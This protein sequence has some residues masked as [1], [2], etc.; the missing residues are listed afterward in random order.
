MDSAKLTIERPPASLMPI[1]EQIQEVGLDL[2][3]AIRA[4]C[5]LGMAAACLQ[6]TSCVLL[7]SDRRD[8]NVAMVDVVVAAVGSGGE[9]VGAGGR[10]VEL[11]DG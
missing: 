6:P 10:V 3:Y 11:V 1:V 2:E 8:D 5:A 4:W 7:L 9:S